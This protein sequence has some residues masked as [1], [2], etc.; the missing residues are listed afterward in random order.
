VIESWTRVISLEHDDL[1]V[2]H[3][4]PINTDLLLSQNLPRDL[5]DGDEEGWEPFFLSKD[6]TRINIGITTENFVLNEEEMLQA[7]R[8]VT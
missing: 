2:K 7:G 8:E 6:F 5:D 4:Y 3:K 1:D